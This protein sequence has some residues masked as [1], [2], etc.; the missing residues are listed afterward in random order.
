MSPADTVDT[1]QK[2]RELSKYSDLVNYTTDPDLVTFNIS[3][4]SKRQHNQ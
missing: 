4:L 3:F 2:E 1:T